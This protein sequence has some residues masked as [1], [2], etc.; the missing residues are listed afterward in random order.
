MGALASACRGPEASQPPGASFTNPPLPPPK[1]RPLRKRPP[2][3]SP[4]PE[5]PNLTLLWVAGK[6]A[7]FERIVVYQMSRQPQQHA[8]TML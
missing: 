6:S 4:K 1:P 8:D 7:V 5:L 2:E 3:Q